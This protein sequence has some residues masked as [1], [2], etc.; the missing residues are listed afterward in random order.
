MLKKSISLLLAAIITFGILA[1][2]PAPV[3]AAAATTDKNQSVGLS[4]DNVQVSGSNSL[5]S[6]LAEEYEK[7]AENLENTGSGIYAVA[8]EGK[9]ARVDVRAL[10]DA[11]LIV[12][13]FDEEGNTMYGSGMT[14]V[15]TEDIL[16]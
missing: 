9:T 15:S 10:V 5:G 13:V 8:M 4:T 11:Q 3:S 2:I 12:S 7:N 14:D 16:L 1:V 6:M